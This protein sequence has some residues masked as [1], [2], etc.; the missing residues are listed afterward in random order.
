MLSLCLSPRKKS[1][2]FKK[3]ILSIHTKDTPKISIHFLCLNDDD[4]SVMIGTSERIW[5]ARDTGGKTKTS[6]SNYASVA[7]REMWVW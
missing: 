7:V 5:T 3:G 1:L 2:P 6:P 4:T